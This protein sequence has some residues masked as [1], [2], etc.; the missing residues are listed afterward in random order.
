MSKTNGKR[1]GRKNGKP[2]KQAE[3]GATARNAKG[4]FPAGVS[5]NPRGMQTKFATRFRQQLHEFAEA[6]M[7]EDDER[8][9]VSVL[10]QTTFDKALAGDM[11]AMKL[12]WDRLMP[13]TLQAELNV[14]G[15]GSEVVVDV[16][17]CMMQDYAAAGRL[18][19]LT[20]R[21]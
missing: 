7:A 11:Y 16:F 3:A 5:G 15:L 20:S 4:Q 13:A 21:Q 9:R 8:S 14:Q 17:G 18:P 6:N 12:L 2:E 1:N 10:L 19:E